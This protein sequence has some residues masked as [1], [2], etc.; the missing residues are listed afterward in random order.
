MTV[1]EDFPHSPV[2]QSKSPLFPELTTC[3]QRLLVFSMGARL[4]LQMGGY[5]RDQILKDVRIFNSVVAEAGQEKIDA[6]DVMIK[7]KD[8]ESQLEIVKEP[9]RSVATFTYPIDTDGNQKNGRLYVEDR[10]VFDADKNLLEVKRSFR[11]GPG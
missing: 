3:L 10:F 8:A 2:V 7:T 9:S 1:R 11:M 6:A 4:K 5:L